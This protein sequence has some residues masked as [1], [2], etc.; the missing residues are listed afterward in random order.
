MPR[1]LVLFQL[2]FALPD[3]S[4]KGDHDISV[5]VALKDG[6]L[7]NSADLDSDS[8][9]LAA[10][11]VDLRL[12]RFALGFDPLARADIDPS[13]LMLLVRFV[14]AMLDD[15]PQSDGSPTRIVSRVP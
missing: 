5:H 8:L 7:W 11:D 1:I 3:D 9:D 10:G 2:H 12:H 6:S 14:S 15:P 4:M 13:E